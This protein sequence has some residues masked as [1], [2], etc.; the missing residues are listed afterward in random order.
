MT[1]IDNLLD[2]IRRQKGRGYVNRHVVLRHSIGT[3]NLRHRSTSE[4]GA[5]PYERPSDKPMQLLIDLL[6][7]NFDRGLLLLVGAAHLEW[8]HYL[9][10]QAPS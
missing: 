2:D 6:R 5:P 7:T 10:R 1:T 8:R 3:R 9:T 4:Y